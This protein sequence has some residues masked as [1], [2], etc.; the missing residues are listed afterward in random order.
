MD[1]KR[2][3]TSVIHSLSKGHSLNKG[4]GLT[5][6]Y[7]FTK[8]QLYHNVSFIKER[9]KNI[10][11]QHYTNIPSY[12]HNKNNHPNYDIIVIGGGIQGAGVLQAAQAAGYTSLALE[13]SAWAA[14]TSSKSSKLIHGGLRYLQS[15]EFSL[16]KESLQERSLL[17]KNAPGL[18]H[19]NWFHIPVYRHSRYRPWKIWVGLTFYWLLS[20]CRK[21]ARFKIVSKKKW[22]ELKGLK[23]ENLIKVFKYCDAQTD[24]VKLTES[25][26]QSAV[27]LGAEVRCPATLI[28]A[29]QIKGGY[30]VSY[31]EGSVIQ[32][33]TCRFLVNAGGPWINQVAEVVSPQPNTIP[34]ELVQGAHLV[35]DKKISDEC[36]YLESPEDGRAV[37]VLP[38]HEGSLI[39]TTETAFDGNPENSKTTEKEREYLL[40]ILNT[41]FPDYTGTVSAEMAGL[42]VLPQNN[43][44]ESFHHISREVQLITDEKKL[45][46]YLGIYGGKLTGYRATAQKVVKIIEKTLCRRDQRISTKDLLLKEIL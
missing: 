31:E 12:T 27:S 8:E 34:I 10:E 13:K 29:T 25:V 40:N 11:T 7:G 21:E 42:R 1:T 26:I 22:R 20:G 32:T 9:Q 45:P 19:H 43:D 46:H 44:K 16:V 33:A 36:F 14:G 28:S 15:G 23:T 39:G 18:V 2:K 24:D 5:K 4:H 6:E 35:L 38:W 37:F 30:K 3:R 41:Y 17:L